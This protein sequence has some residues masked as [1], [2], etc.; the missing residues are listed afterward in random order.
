MPT[1][2]SVLTPLASPVAASSSLLKSPYTLMC[3]LPLH[4]S[5]DCSVRP[6]PH[7][8]RNHRRLRRKTSPRASRAPSARSASK[9]TIT[10]A[11]PSS[12]GSIDSLPSASVSSSPSPFPH[13]SLSASTSPISRATSPS[14]RR[15]KSTSPSPPPLQPISISTA[16]ELSDKDKTNLEHGPP[17]P[18]PQHFPIGAR[19][20]SFSG[21]N[22]NE[23]GGFSPFAPPPAMPTTA[24]ATGS[25]RSSLDS[26]PLASTSTS[27]PD[28]STF[29]PLANPRA[30]TMVT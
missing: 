30:S 1:P 26:L 24:V 9:A 11:G 10:P 28:A 23:G 19:A 13:S 22:T 18:Y 21:A 29:A 3:R 16:F 25:A 5:L 2:P 14:P 17:L 6:C 15:S 7:Q 20:L 12:S 27:L 4:C 8:G